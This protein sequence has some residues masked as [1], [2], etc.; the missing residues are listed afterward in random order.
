MVLQNSKDILYSSLPEETSFTS[1]TD[2]Q[3][4][5][6]L[7]V[8]ILCAAIKAG[9]CVDLQN[10]E[11]PNANKS[12]IPAHMTILIFHSAEVKKEYEAILQIY[13]NPSHPS[14][15]MAGCVHSV[16]LNS[17]NLPV[18]LCELKETHIPYV[19]LKFSFEK[20]RLW[21]TDSR[22][23]FVFC[24]YLMVS[25]SM[26]KLNNMICESKDFNLTQ[27]IDISNKITKR[28]ESSN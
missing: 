15:K 20:R 24:F 18:V 2:D 8:L 16:F 22:T 23:H 28:P 9:D 11:D 10:L 6:Q 5:I 7:R 19:L 14:D 4:R 1:P 27:S 12:V 17:L 3:G 21:F 26:D 25:F 13:H